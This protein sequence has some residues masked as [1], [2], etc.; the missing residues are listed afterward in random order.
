MDPVRRKAI[1][2][3]VVRLSDGDR[4]AFRVLLDELWPVILAF[5]QRGLH[6]EQDAEDA[7]QEVFL[8]ICSRISDFDRDR[9]G[10]SWA[11]GIASYEVMTHRRRQQRT[12]LTL[13]EA[14]VERHIDPT[15]SPEESVIQSDI[16]AALTQATGVLSEEDRVALELA[17]APHQLEFAVQGPT[18][19]KRRQRALG[20][21]RVIWRNLNGRP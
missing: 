12:R 4:S 13:D 5:T 2:D 15:E 6:H 1:H 8:R 17:G 14:Q 21:L 9:D 19:R 11:F 20:R 10:L 3:A 7:A 16:L 18:L